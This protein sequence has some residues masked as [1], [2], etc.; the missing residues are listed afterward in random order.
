M[1]PREALPA[2]VRPLQPRGVSAV[3]A[4]ALNLVAQQGRD[5]PLTVGEGTWTVSLI[6]RGTSAEIDKPWTLDL[7]WGDDHFQLT[8]PLASARRWLAVQ[9]PDLQLDELPEAFARAVLATACGQAFAV[10]E[11]QGLGAVTVEPG[12]P[13]ST[14][15]ARRAHVFDLVLRHGT[16]ELRGAIATRTAGLLHLA[17]RLASLPS[18]PGVLPVDELP[19]P[20][21]AEVG[22]TWITLAEWHSVRTGD[23]VMVER[24]L[25][26]PE[27][28]VW[29]GCGDWGLRVVYRD[30]TLQVREQLKQGGWRMRSDDDTHDT[31]QVHALAHLPLRVTFDLG[32]VAMTVGEVAALQVGQLIE[33]GQPLSDAVHIRING[34]RVGFGELVD[35]DGQLGVLVRSLASPN[36]EMGPGT[37]PQATPAHRLA[38]TRAEEMIP[39]DEASE[40]EFDLPLHDPEFDAIDPPSHGAR[41]T[42]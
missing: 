25:L 18:R 19:C 30:G 27:G 15:A 29:F 12:H 3:E 14:S 41:G 39:D 8:L 37:I 9:F 7:Q 24:P 13:G 5:L 20:W 32:E 10:L 16:S 22:F 38:D 28:E 23:A 31:G 17:S 42:V 4:R 2:S 1:Q 40:D 35:I 11:S 36:L 34:A 6:P 26:S 33:L 21:R